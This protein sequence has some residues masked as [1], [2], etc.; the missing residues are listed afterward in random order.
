MIKQTCNVAIFATFWFVVCCSFV[1]GQSS[2]HIKGKITEPTVFAD[3]NNFYQQPIK[4]IAKSFIWDNEWVV[5]VDQQ[6][7]FAIDLP[8]D[9]PLAVELLYGDYTLP[10]FLQSNDELEIQFNAQQFDKSITFSGKAAPAANYC[11]RRMQRFD[12]NETAIKLREARNNG[13]PSLAQ[14]TEEFQLLE[15]DLLQQFLRQY[16]TLNTPIFN[17]WAKN[18]IKY[19][20]INHLSNYFFKTPDKYA[21]GYA[22]FAQK[23]PYNDENALVSYEYCKFVDNHLRQLC[24]RDSPEQR[25]ERETKGEPWHLRALQIAE[26]HLKGKVLEYQYAKL[27]LD[28]LSAENETVLSFANTYPRLI[29]S[30]SLQSLL[31]QQFADFEKK[32]TALPPPNAN[33]YTLN[34]DDFDWQQWLSRY[35]GKVVYIDFWASWCKPCLAEFTK[36]STFKQPFEGQNI[37]F[38]YITADDN[39]TIWRLSIARYQIEG[40]HY[41]LPPTSY[42]QLMQQL[43]VYSLPRYLIVDQQGNIVV[44]NAPRP[45]DPQAAQL[46]RQIMAK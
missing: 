1:Y 28:L 12:T 29:T 23:Y 40:D 36:A 39:P 24:L 14:T 10:L 27:L 44:E 30:P 22:D 5:L 38:V 7:N 11:L 2:V 46:L 3:K 35:K 41:W 4:I 37:A 17:S 31:R 15:Q 20:Y 26:S 43:G 21:D 42:K 8:I 25:A 32:L 34:Q 18:E 6:G 16:P 45:T 9:A 13:L 19:R 33:L